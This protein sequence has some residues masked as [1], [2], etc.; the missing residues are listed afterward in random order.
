MSGFDRVWWLHA[1]REWLTVLFAAAILLVLA[2]FF[3]QPIVAQRDVAGIVRS[4]RRAGDFAP[5]TPTARELVLET[6]LDDGRLVR[7]FSDPRHP[8][9][10]GARIVLRE[11]VYLLGMRRYRWENSEGR[12]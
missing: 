2:F 4:I 3:L 10:I 11:S 6:Q 7:A 9:A 8:P 12:R 1:K 5:K